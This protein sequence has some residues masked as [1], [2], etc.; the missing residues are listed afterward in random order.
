MT[1]KTALWLL[2]IAAIVLMLGSASVILE[3]NAEPRPNVPTGF[4]H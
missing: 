2:V 1:R 3:R 4:L